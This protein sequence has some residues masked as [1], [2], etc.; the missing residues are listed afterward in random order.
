MAKKLTKKQINQIK[1][2][3]VKHP[4]G[5]IIITIIILLALIAGALYYFLV[6]N[7]PE[8]KTYFK[9]KGPDTVSVALEGTYE[10]KGFECFYKNEDVSSSVTTTYYDSNNQVVT[11]I[12][13]SKE[14]TFTAKYVADSKY[15]F[16]NNTLT[17]TINVTAVEP[18]L[19]SFL[20][21]GNKYTGDSIYIKAGETDI[22]IDAGSQKNSATAISNYVNQHCTDGKLEYVIAT[23][24]HEDHIAAFVGSK[25]DGTGI[26][27]NYKIK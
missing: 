13:T 8:V 6:L 3:V 25:T 16:E 9:L 15:S 18:L 7:K 20:E 27:N 4:K 10:E 1:K 22:L 5:G 21:L 11:S 17:R 2:T 24:A 26:F 12:D 23:H 19:I 14:A